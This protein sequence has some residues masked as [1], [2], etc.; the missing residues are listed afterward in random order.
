MRAPLLL[1]ALLWAQQ[2]I[3]D[4]AIRFWVPS[5][6]YGGYFPA[7]DLAK[8]FGYSSVIGGEIGYKFRNHLLITLQGGGLVGDK[9]TEPKLLDSLFLPSLAAAGMLAFVDENGRIF[10]PNLRQRGWT[11]LLRI[12]KL[13]PRLRFPGQNPNCGPFIEIGIGYLSHRILIDKARS[14][15]LPLLE[16]EY[17]KGLDRLTAG[18]GLSESI[19]YR[20]FSNRGLI[21][22]FIAVEAGQYFTRSLR[23]YMYD[24]GLRDTKRRRDFWQGF[25]VGW[26]LPLYEKS[27]TE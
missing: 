21:N 13:F 25:R 5:V 24:R 9:V 3:R 23:G 26:S 2:S 8:R 14:E 18:W 19:G 16:G 4:S 12:G 1:F 7:A 20:F 6:V 22:F 27:P 15:R 17:L 10:T 11:A